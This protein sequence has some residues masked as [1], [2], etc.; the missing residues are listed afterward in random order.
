MDQA[1]QERIHKVLERRE[2][3]RQATAALEG[4]EFRMAREA[5]ERIVSEIPAALARLKAAVDEVNDAVSD[6]DL[7]LIQD[8]VEQPFTIE[9]SFQVSIWPDDDRHLAL[10]FN[11]SH[12]GKLIALL[13]NRQSRV[14]LNTCDIWAADR[15]FF[16]DALVSLLEAAA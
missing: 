6:S 2:R 4:D 14:R 10:M 15:R 9:A 16:Q 7:R 3:E 5:H 11:V 12:D 1:L 13:C 8:G